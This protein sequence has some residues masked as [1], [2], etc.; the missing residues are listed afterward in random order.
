MYYCKLGCY[1]RIALP[2][3]TYILD[4]GQGD[5][6]GDGV[7]DN[8]YLVGE[9]PM[10]PDSPFYDNIAVLIQNCW[11]GQV[12]RITFKFNA[13][14]NPKLFVGDFT[15]D[16]VMDIYVSI[17]SGG[18]GGFG[19]FYIF[20]FRNNRVR[21]LFDFEEYNQ[22]SKYRVTYRDCYAVDVANLNTLKLFG[23]DIYTKGADYLLEIY[24]ENGKLKE[25][26]E[27]EV[28]GLAEVFPID[29]NKDS[30]FEILAVQRVIG[31]FNADTLGFVQTY[32]RW[33]GTKFAQFNQEVSVRGVDLISP[34]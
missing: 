25:P 17:E 27:G 28:L 33:D 13:G 6:N 30:N 32:L 21:K 22:Q 7:I 24:D 9:K 16:S 8:V 31:R 18:S 12:T 23:I 14:Y 2:L 4:F 3:N 26:I 5:V 19:F 10:G 34:A 11:N 20:S 15:N 1:P 29:V